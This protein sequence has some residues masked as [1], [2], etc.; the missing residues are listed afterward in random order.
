MI[1]RSVLSGSRVT[2][3]NRIAQA[4]VIA[5]TTCMVLLVQ[6]STV[7][8]AAMPWRYSSFIAGTDQSANVANETTRLTA[9]GCSPTGEECIAAGNLLSRSDKLLLAL[10]N[11]SHWVQLATPEV[12]NPV[13]ISGASCPNVATCMIVGQQFIGNTSIEPFIDTLSVATKHWSIPALPT[14]NSNRSVLTSISCASPVSCFA[15]GNWVDST[16]VVHPLVLRFTGAE[17]ILDGSALQANIGMNASLLS[18]S[19]AVHECIA[20]GISTTA[21]SKVLAVRLEGNGGSRIIWN[22]AIQSVRDE[23]VSCNDKQCLIVVTF[24]GQSGLNVEGTRLY[25]VSG[26]SVHQ[27]VNLPQEFARNDFRTVYCSMESPVCIVG[28]GVSVTSIGLSYTRPALMEISGS[29]M[30]A[31]DVPNAFPN[32]SGT[33]ASLGGTVNGAYFAVGSVSPIGRP[34]DQIAVLAEHTVHPQGMDWAILA[35]AGIAVLIL[36]GV[37]VFLLLRKGNR[38]HHD[39]AKS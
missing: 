35:A 9:V 38:V 5:A 27:L 19:C 12:K 11:G 10:W 30:T 6:A 7:S 33:F 17:W 26:D 23:S 25:Q 2:F 20:T 22:E 39:P 21:P 13:L 15:V 34:Q 28:G 32:T 29:H 3:S 31:L 8:A 36:A 24:S 37:G 14:V 16:A 4:A 1:M 18:V